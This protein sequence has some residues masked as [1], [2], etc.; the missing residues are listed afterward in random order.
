MLTRSALLRFLTLAALAS[1]CSDPVRDDAIAALGPEDSGG[2]GP[3][4]RPGQPCLLCH[5]S[6]GPA[7]SKAFAIAGTVYKSSAANADGA[8]N[9]VV[10]FIDARGGAPVVVPTTGPTGN[11]YVPIGDWPTMAFPVRVGLY[12]SLDGPPVEIMKS[13]INREGSCNYC[14]RPN[15]GGDSLTPDQIDQ[16]RSS[17]GQIFY[18]GS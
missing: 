12:D 9:V 10:Q 2:P 15:P 18:K 3:D 4:H 7:S 14:H 11:F 17:A 5:S 1:G 6:G 13:L 8:D 16:S